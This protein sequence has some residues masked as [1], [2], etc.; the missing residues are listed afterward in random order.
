[1]TRREMLLGATALACLPLSVRFAFAHRA[2]PPEATAPHQHLRSMLMNIFP[3]PA[4]PQALGQAYLER[5]PA[6]ADVRLLMRSFQDDADLPEARDLAQRLGERR[7]RD[8]RDGDTVVVEGWVL[9][10]SEA[11]LCA[12]TVLL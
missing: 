11:R 10:R 1:M 12:L 7:S 3:D 8:F 6:E 5:Y 4:A 9:A 2:L